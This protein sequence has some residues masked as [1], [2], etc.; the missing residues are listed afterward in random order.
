M[1][2]GKRLILTLA[3][4][5]IIFLII[6]TYSYHIL[7]GWDYIDSLYFSTVTLTTIGYGDLYPTNNVSKLFTV[8]FILSGVG[9]LLFALT[10]ISS[11]IGKKKK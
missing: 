6:G 1:N 9:I 4:L 5:I 7:E 2:H 3:V 10:V 11:N 8:F